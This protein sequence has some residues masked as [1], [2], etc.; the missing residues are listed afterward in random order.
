MRW[1][2]WC[3]SSTRYVIFTSATLVAVVDLPFIFFIW[4][5]SLIAG[6]LALVPLIAVPIV[7]ILGLSYSL[8]SLLWQKFYAIK[9]VQ[10][11]R[12]N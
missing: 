3:V 10:T 2:A 7:I 8:F 5:I 6:P 9:H 1:L 12:F 4:V 11:R